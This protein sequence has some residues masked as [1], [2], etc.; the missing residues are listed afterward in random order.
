MDYDILHYDTP[1]AIPSDIRQKILDA[2]C[3]VYDK[4]TS[5]TFEHELDTNIPYEYVVI[6]DRTTHVVVGLGCI[7]NSGL[8]FDI[9]EF[10]WGLVR[11]EYQG[12]GYGKI[13]NN[14][15]IKIVKQ[16]HGKEIF[17]VTNKVWHLKHSGFC[18]I[19][20]LSN[21]DNLMVREV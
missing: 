20:T 10:A 18:P 1:N 15:R 16:K 4:D 3:D 8:D 9:W 11:K 5:N 12:M 14:E 7:M 21:G 13:L 2:V 6:V 19:Y 17:A